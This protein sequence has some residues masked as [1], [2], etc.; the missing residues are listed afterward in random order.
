MPI[1]N[2][3]TSDNINLENIYERYS[4]ETF[5]VAD[6]FDDA[7]I[8]VDD[9]KMILCYSTRKIISI[10]MEREEMEYDDAME[11]FY[12]NIKGSYL[13]EKTPLFIDDMF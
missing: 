11:H 10:L 4:D 2:E 3:F 13:G 8:G 7:V 6:G 9:N 1:L 5:L 12:Y